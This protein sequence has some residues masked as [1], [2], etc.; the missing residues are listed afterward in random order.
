MILA[1]TLLG[2]ALTLVV[3]TIFSGLLVLLGTRRKST[4]G[5]AAEGM[6]P[7][8]VKDRKH[9]DRYYELLLTSQSKISHLL[10]MLCRT[11]KIRT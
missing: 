10:M 5:G 8:G 1:T 6:K 9:R 11:Q 7:S 2:R 3:A 4:H